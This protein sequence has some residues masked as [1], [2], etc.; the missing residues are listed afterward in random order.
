M[1]YKQFFINDGDN[2]LEVIV[3]KKNNL[4]LS[5]KKIGAKKPIEIILDI[6]DTR[7]LLSE[8]NIILSEF[9]PF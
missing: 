6:E 5:I 4:V 1:N 2:E 3:P 8:L 7:A 9:D